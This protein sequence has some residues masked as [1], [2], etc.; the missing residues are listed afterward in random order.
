MQFI[1]SSIIK[2]LNC[3]SFGVYLNPLKI[4]FKSKYIITAF[5]LI[6]L[7]IIGLKFGLGNCNNVKILNICEDVASF[8]VDLKM[9]KKLN[10][11][12]FKSIESI[13]SVL[14]FDSNGEIISRETP[15]NNSISLNSIKEKE[16]VVSFISN[17]KLAFKSILF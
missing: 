5:F 16:L 17:N 11:L 8:D 4:M 6:S 9:N 12:E 2:C 15:I 7:S 1:N 10:A 13:N 14:I 3:S